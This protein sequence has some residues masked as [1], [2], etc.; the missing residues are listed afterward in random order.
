MKIYSWKD[1]LV[2]VFVGGGFIIYLLLHFNEVTDF[3]YLI[4]FAYLVLKRITISIDKEEYDAEKK[5]EAKMKKVY[6]KLFG[7]FAPVAPYG[8]IIFML[9]GCAFALLFPEVEWVI[10]WLL[11]ILILSALAYNIWLAIIIRKHMKIEEEQERV[12][13]DKME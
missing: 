3:F 4:I 8:G 10:E 12:V 13:S 9:L 11:L 1:L 6:R 2:S 5:R 7:K